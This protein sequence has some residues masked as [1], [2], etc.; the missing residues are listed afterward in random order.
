M[1]AVLHGTFIKQRPDGQTRQQVVGIPMGG[2]SSAELANLYCY[3]VES[4]TIDALLQNGQEDLV[5]STYHTVRYIDDILGFGNA[6]THCFDYQM[7]H[8][9]TNDQPH[10]AVFLGMRIT[11]SGDFVQLSHEPKGAGWKWK[12]QRYVEWASIHTKD[13]KRMILKGLLVRSGT[14]TNTMAA[15][16]DSVRYIIDGL[17]AR[18]FTRR[19]LTDSFESYMKDY[20]GPFTHAAHDVKKWF[21]GE[22]DR[23]Y[24]QKIQPFQAAAKTQPPAPPTQAPAAIPPQF[25]ARGTLLC[26][27]T[28]INHVMA[29]RGRV[30]LSRDVLDDVALH[31]ANLE[32][33]IRAEGTSVDTSR[34]QLPHHGDEPRPDA[35]RGPPCVR[36][37][38]GHDHPG[39]RIRHR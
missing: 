38:A 22:L 2:K 15:F 16:K 25:S 9:Q 28:A 30:P 35:P 13:T 14:I 29:S 1:N 19:A 18:G 32:A 20:W 6:L 3:S 34:R 24:K 17:Y 10:T 33:S 4:A 36:L 5:R 11:T 7:E 26:G 37:E 31:V 8:K 27:L 23:L 21:H 12:P 39:L